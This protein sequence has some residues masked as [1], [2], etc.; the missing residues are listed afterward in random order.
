MRGLIWISV[1]ALGAEISVAAAFLSRLPAEATR[2]TPLQVELA[3]EVLRWSRYFGPARV[4]SAAFEIVL[5]SRAADSIFQALLISSSSR[6]A[7]LYAFYGIQQINPQLAKIVAER[8][9]Q[10]GGFV[11]LYRCAAAYSLPAAEVVSQ[12]ERGEWVLNGHRTAP[13]EHEFS[14]G[15]RYRR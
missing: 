6:A 5:E 3:A 14:W 12:I 8:E 10:I 11:V 2:P 15:L 7:R 4:E 1:A 13:C 9:R